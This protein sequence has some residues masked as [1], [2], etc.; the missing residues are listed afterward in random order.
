[1][2]A[3]ASLLAAVLFAAVAFLAAVVL[4]EA[5]AVGATPAGPAGLETSGRLRPSREVSGSGK[6]RQPI[7][8]SSG[9]KNEHDCFGS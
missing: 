4:F 3:A 8:G 6:T 2:A 7:S 5:A 9:H 1:M